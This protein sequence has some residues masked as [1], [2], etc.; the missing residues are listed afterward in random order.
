VSDL[1]EGRNAVREALR[2]GTPLQEILV[3][4]GNRPAPV[5]DEIRSLAEGAGIPVRSV[6]K[7][8]LDEMSVR[9]AHQGVLAVADDFAYADLS[10]ILESEGDRF[11]IVLDH[12]VDPGNLGAVVRS[13]EALG[14]AAVVIP[15]ARAAAMSAIAQKTSAGAAAHLPIVR[16]PNIAAALRS[17][18]DAGF[19]V[20][21]ASER[22]EQDVGDARLDGRIAVV[23]G[24]EGEGIS[25]LVRETCDFL[26]RIPLAGRTSSLNVAQAATVFLYEWAR[27]R[28]S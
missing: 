9:G 25:R 15:K 28:S 26:V 10:S 21:G 5:L 18:K 17:L 7:G 8:R 22:A 2:A 19:W 16:V 3:A 1:L 20:A 14:A 13:A 24:A 27:G 6:D 12:V 4:K 23:L 11:V